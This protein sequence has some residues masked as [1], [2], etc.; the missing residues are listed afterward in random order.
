[1]HQLSN[2]NKY[3]VLFEDL[4]AIAETQIKTLFYEN[5]FFGGS[6]EQELNH[7]KTKYKTGKPDFLDVLHKYYLMTTL[8]LHK[9]S[10]KH[11][12]KTI[13]LVIIINLRYR[14]YKKV[15][16]YYNDIVSREI[17]SLQNLVPE[18]DLNGK[19]HQIVKVILANV[20]TTF[21]YSKLLFPRKVQFKLEKSFY[22]GYYIGVN[23]IIS[24]QILDSTKYTKNEKLEFHNL[25]QHVLSDSDYSHFANGRFYPFINKIITDCKLRFPYGENEEFYKILFLLEQSQFEDLCF[26]YKK[27]ETNKLVHKSSLVALK[28]MFSLIAVNL[29]LSRKLDDNINNSILWTLYCQ[30]TDDIRDINEDRE[31]N[32]LTLFTLEEDKYKFNP[33]R[34][35]IFL[36]NKFAKKYY[37][38]WMYSDLLNMLNDSEIH[39]KVKQDDRKINIFTNKILGLKFA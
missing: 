9:F 3:T 23:Y 39:S 8:G 13:F 5:D 2:L 1:M 19:K 22:M 37:A 18:I 36:T 21:I 25:V 4:Y 16:R 12:F 30:M 38:S 29:K 24:D 27:G 33:Y 34:L 11:F 7:I 35:Y 6:H 32:I 28:T 20:L 15:V 10:F 31:Q 26:N 14:R 17:N